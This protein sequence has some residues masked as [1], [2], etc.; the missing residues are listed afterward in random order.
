MEHKKSLVGPERSRSR[1][2]GVNTWALQALNVG[3][4]RKVVL[5]ERQAHIT[6]DIGMKKAKRL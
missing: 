6:K 5:K 2:E 4:H 3:L 1:R